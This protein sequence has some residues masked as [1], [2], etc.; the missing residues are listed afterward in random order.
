[1]FSAERKNRQGEGKS[2]SAYMDLYMQSFESLQDVSSHDPEY[3]YGE[4]GYPIVL[5]QNNEDVSTLNLLK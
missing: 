5:L 3:S 4:K 1:M 2:H